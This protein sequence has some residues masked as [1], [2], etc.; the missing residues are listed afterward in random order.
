VSGLIDAHLHATRLERPVPEGILAYVANGTAPADWPAVLDLARADLRAHAAIGLHPWFVEDSLD[1]WQTELRRLLVANP[2]ASV[3][4]IGLDRAARGIALIAD[5]LEVFVAQLA[6]AAEL[7]RV[8][9]VHAVRVDAELLRVLRGGPV[10]ARG[11]LLHAYGGAAEH[12]PELVTLGCRFSFSPGFE[13]SPARVEA[14]RRVP[15]DRLLVET[16]SPSRGRDPDDLSDTYAALAALRGV[17]V[18]EL[19]GVVAETF[20]ALFG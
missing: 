15:A 20:A 2:R 17:G 7:G 14:F 18:E 6:L 10:P 12:V 9:S 16:D 1:G 4:E 8:A 13:R 3:G 5:Q 19:A 11:V